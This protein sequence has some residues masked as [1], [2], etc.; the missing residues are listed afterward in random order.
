MRPRQNDYKLCQKGIILLEILVAFAILSISLTVIL[1]TAGASVR[2]Q[3]ITENRIV[4]VS[5]A[6]NVLARLDIDI[7]L[8]GSNLEGTLDDYYSWRVEFTQLNRR[9]TLAVDDSG[10]VLAS[11]AIT[12]EWLEGLQQKNYQIETKRIIRSGKIAN[13]K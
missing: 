8:D 4:A 12:I 11:V 7:P 3:R 1:Q 9:D 13:A 10:L 2:H 5:H 6:A